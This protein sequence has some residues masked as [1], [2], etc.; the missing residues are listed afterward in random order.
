MQEGVVISA[1]HHTYP[2]DG[3]SPRRVDVDAVLEFR[4]PAFPADRR[5]TD[6]FR[7]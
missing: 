3:A 4:L 7:P 5:V 6:V 1:A 2:P